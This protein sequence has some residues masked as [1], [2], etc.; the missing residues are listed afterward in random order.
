MN[1]HP[2]VDFTKIFLHAFFCTNVFIL[3]KF[4]FVRMKK[5]AQKMLVK[6]TPDECFHKRQSKRGHSN[7]VIP[8]KGLFTQDIFA[9]NIGAKKR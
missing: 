5:G 1:F 9:H 7:N 4:C 8:S 3:V 6:L 2:G